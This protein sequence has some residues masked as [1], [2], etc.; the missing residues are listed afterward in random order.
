MPKKQVLFLDFFVKLYIIFFMTED[1]LCFVAVEFVDDPN[2]VGY[3]Y[4]YLCPFTGVAESDRVTAPLGRH[5]N[6][7]EGV[8]RRVLFADEYTAP[9]PIYLIK[10]VVKVLK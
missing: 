3:N 6:L 10:S 2:V 4:W 9:Y 8:V 1:K 7:Q 5:N